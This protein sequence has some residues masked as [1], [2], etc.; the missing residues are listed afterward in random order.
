MLA[1]PNN[2][3]YGT[4]PSVPKYE[5]VNKEGVGVL[6]T[7]PELPPC[8]GCSPVPVSPVSPADTQLLLDFKASFSNGAALLASW[9]PGTDPCADKW[10]GIICSNGTLKEM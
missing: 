4:L 5:I 7:Q 3:F 2:S 6:L 1:L 8:P 10:Q 9:V